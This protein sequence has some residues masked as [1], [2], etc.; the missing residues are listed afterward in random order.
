MA[1]KHQDTLAG[2]GWASAGGREMIAAFAERQWRLGENLSYHG[3][4][5]F[6]DG[7]YVGSVVASFAD[8]TMQPMAE[9]KFA[10][11]CASHAFVHVVI[12][13][14]KAAAA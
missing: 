3:M 11:G 1:A 4:T 2:Q 6:G 12:V 9:A 7:G 5:M 10:Y 8:G 14:A 13:S